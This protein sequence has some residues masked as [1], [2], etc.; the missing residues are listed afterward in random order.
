[1]AR[2]MPTHPTQWEYETYRPPRDETKKE[3]T[4]P[5][6]EL[7]RRGA[8]GWEFVG[9]IDYSGGGTKYLVFKRP[10]EVGEPP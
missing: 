6:A 8:G 10:A 9:T 2:I 4:D 3:A 7:N 1:M 5:E